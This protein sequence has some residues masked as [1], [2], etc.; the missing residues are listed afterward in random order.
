M[1]IGFY[2]ALAMPMTPKRPVSV[3]VLSQQ[4]IGMSYRKR[5]EHQHYRS[6]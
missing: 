3:K 6:S 5:D 1:L 2:E 4:S